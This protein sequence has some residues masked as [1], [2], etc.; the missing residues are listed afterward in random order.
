MFVR[1]HWDVLLVDDEPDV[2]AISHLVLKEIQVYGISLRIHECSSKA[3]AIRY[4]Q[5]TA[6][7]SDLSLAIVDIV[8]ET[9]HAG[10]DIC[11]FIREDLN[12]RVTPIVVRTGQAGKTPEREVIDRY[13][14]ST[15][16]T[17]VE[18]TSEKLYATVV[19]A[20]RGYQYARIYE[21][22]LGVTSRLIL[23]SEIREDI[24]P[25]MLGFINKI[26]LRRDGR[27]LDYDQLHFCFLTESEDIAAGKFVGQEAEA[28]ALRDRLA[29]EPSRIIN[30][31][32]D[33]FTRVDNHMLISLARADDIP[34]FDMVGETNYQPIPDYMLRATAAFAH[35]VRDLLFMADKR[36]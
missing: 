24:G 36:G 22:F 12:N 20:V 9:E 5:A 4:L 3:D 8:M 19:N 33:R 17:K 2:L 29:K 23:R 30:A 34:G 21:T 14:I 1:K 32:G 11:K 26:L 35:C 27:P 15:Y 13:D 6:E 31:N 7:L 28:H 10:L 18:A 25:A 16:L